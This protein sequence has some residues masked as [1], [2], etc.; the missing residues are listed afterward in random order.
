[1]RELMQEYRTSLEQEAIKAEME[2]QL[3]ATKKL[4]FLKMLSEKARSR[5]SNI[6][7][8]RPEFAKQIEL[9]LLQLIQT[10]QIK[11][12]ISD[13]QLINI[14]K[15]IKGPRREYRIIK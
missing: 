15:K 11:E 14:I 3:E 7:L 6:R 5:L 9:L 13:H 10:G 4:I 2:Q 1:M 8:A 12:K